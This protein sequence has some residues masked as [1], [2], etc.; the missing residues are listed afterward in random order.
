ML[1]YAAPFKLLQPLHLINFGFKIENL[2]FVSFIFDKTT[3]SSS[4][5]NLLNTNVVSSHAGLKGV[6]VGVMGASECGGHIFL[7]IPELHRSR[8]FLPKQSSRMPNHCKY[9]IYFNSKFNM[10]FQR[11][12][13][14]LRCSD[15][16]SRSLCSGFK[17]KSE[18]F[19]HFCWAARK[20]VLY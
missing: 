10:R 11:K 18:S 3:G 13:F 4:V 14:A 17:Y 1:C 16:E 5:K 12:N 15:C 6:V 7:I 9:K 2:S 19:K 20:I 8:L